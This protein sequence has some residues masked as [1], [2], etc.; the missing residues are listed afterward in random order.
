MPQIFAVHDNGH[1]LSAAAKYGRVAF[2]FSRE[3]KINVFAADLLVRTVRERL[4]DATED[5]YLVLTGNTIACCVAYSYLL[6]TFGRVNILIFSF[7]NSEYEL[8]TIRDA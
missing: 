4:A 3:E 5:D 8:R 7:R 2:L 6:K 1:D